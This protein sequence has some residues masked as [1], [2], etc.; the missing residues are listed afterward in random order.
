MLRS[1]SAV[2][3]SFWKADN[4]KEASFYVGFRV[5]KRRDLRGGCRRQSTSKTDENVDLAKA[6]VLENRRITISEVANVLEA[7]CA[8][9]QSS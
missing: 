1:N 5:Q 8:E 3:S 4:R 6:F 9:V 2:E 7:S